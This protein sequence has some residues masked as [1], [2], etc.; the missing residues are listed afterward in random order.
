MDR[1]SLLKKIGVSGAGLMVLPV[2]MSKFYEVNPAEEAWKS[3][4]RFTR[5][6][7]VFRY[8]EPDKELPKVFL[9]GDSI[10]IGY[11]EYTRAALDGQA[12]VIRLHRNG[13]SSHNFIEYMETLRKTMF[14]P[15]LE[16]GWDFGW[17]LIHFNV[18]L[19][20]LK[21]VTEGKLDRENG[22]QVSSIKEYR[23]N[24]EKI[25]SY[26]EKTWPDARLVFATTTPVPDNERGRIKGDSARY[27]E[28]ALEIL[29]KY[30]QVIINDLYAYI[31]PRFD[32]LAIRPG[33]VHFS[34]EGSRILG[35]RVGKFI[36]QIMK[37]D[38]VPIPDEEFLK[39]Q[40]RNYLE[41][42]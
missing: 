18:G 17:D 3:L 33:N 25:I 15:Y 7:Y 37:T 2:G 12:N 11:T 39:E 28:A 6:R 8:I 34:K 24:L 16:N 26:L 13:G 30:D 41:S 36:A 23:H 27:N 32:D 10:S 19:H 21:Y 35:K 29:R 4:G 1:R 22:T 42:L 14:H 40:E 38:T 5:E 9:Y 31:N 20:D